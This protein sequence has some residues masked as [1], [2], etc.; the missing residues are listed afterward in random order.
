MNISVNTL[1]SFEQKLNPLGYLP[2]IS[3][4]SGTVRALFGIAEMISGLAKAA[5]QT[6]NPNRNLETQKTRIDFDIELCMHGLANIVRGVIESIPL[7]GN[8]AC[9]CFDHADN[10]LEYRSLDNRTAKSGLFR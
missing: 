10:R 8:A 6:M 1:K 4:V 5:F 9:L 3:I 2:G 7:F